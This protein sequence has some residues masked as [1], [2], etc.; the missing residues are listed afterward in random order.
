M[1]IF[2]IGSL[3]IDY[4]YRVNHIALPGE[5]IASSS[6]QRL[7]GGKG[8]NQSVA[9]SRA[10]A[11]VLHVGSVGE[12]GAFLT[13]FLSENGVNVGFI[14]PSAQVTGHAI[15]Q[16]ADGGENSI[17]I[18]GGANR[19]IDIARVRQLLEK[20]GEPGDW[21]LLQNEINGTAEI[22]ECAAMQNMNISFNPAPYDEHIADLPLHLL[23]LLIINQLE[24]KQLSGESAPDAMTATLTERYPTAAIVLTMGSDGARYQK[25]S[26]IIT[27]QAPPVEAVDTTAA[28]DTFVGYLVALL[29]QGEPISA[30]L[31]IACAAAAQAVTKIGAA[32]SIPLRSDL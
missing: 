8:L 28:G 14:Q 25:E 12:D 15:I 22:I 5:T 24:G 21:L 29:S 30:A 20:E 13:H 31:T 3:N 23:H 32:Q 16:V 17:V 27:K 2:S 9:A 18:H 1:K 6:Y 26:E 11:M 4:V 10:G 19:L 7:C